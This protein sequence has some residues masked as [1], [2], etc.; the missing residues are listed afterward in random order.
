M[1]C[2]RC[3]GGLTVGDLIHVIRFWAKTSAGEPGEYLPVEAHLLDAGEVA[4]RLFDLSLTAQQQ[5]WIADGFGVSVERARSIAAFTA[6]SH[7]IGK[8]G[9]FQHLVP[10][11]ARALGSAELPGFL[12]APKRHDRVSGY[13]L[14]GY[15]VDH[16]ASRE[17]AE[18]L[19]AT[20]CG[21][22]S[23]PAAIPGAERRGQL[24]VLA[25]WRSYHESLLS[26]VADVFGPLSFEDVEVPGHGVTLALAGL[27]NV[28]DWN[29][30]DV[31]R[32]PV[33]TQERRGSA[34]LADDAIVRDAWRPRPVTADVSFSGAF[35]F[36][37]RAS[38]AAL[39]DLL[40]GTELP[41]LIL[42]EDRTG[43][44]KTEAAL[45]AS[46]HALATGARGLFVGLP[47]RAT[48]NQF[49]ARAARFLDSLWNEH[50]HDLRLLHGG[51]HPKDPADPEL[52]DTGRD[53]A[54]DD[55]V[56]ARMWFDG[57]RRGLLSPYAVGTVD[58]ALLAVLAA[59]F[60][61]VRLWGLAGKVVVIDEAHSY[62]TYTAGLLESLL[63]WLGAMDCTVVVLS[64][65][66]PRKIRQMLVAAYR[67]G[68]Q[69]P[70]ASPDGSHDAAGYPRL[71]LANRTV[72]CTLAVMDPRPGRSIRVKHASYVDD[73]AAV[74][75]AAIAAAQDGGCVAVVC[76]T[77]KL[78]QERFAAVRSAQ[79]E[80]PATLLHA[81]IRPLE[82]GPIEAA[83]ASQ[84]GP[85]AVGEA[86][87]RRLVVVATQV[88]EQSLD[89]DFDVMFTD[90]APVD[91]LVQR[92]GRVHRHERIGRPAA[93]REPVLTV[94]DA[95]GG[96]AVHRSLPIGA[97]AVYVNAVL[98]RTR[99]ALRG[100]SAIREPDDLDELIESVYGDDPPAGVGRE[101]RVAIV[102]QDRRAAEQAARHRAWAQ[103]N[104]I[105]PPHGEDPPWEQ[106]TSEI[107]D[108][109]SPG[110]G[111]TH[112]AVTRWSELPSIELVVLREDEAHLAARPA[113]ARDLLLRSV[114]ISDR[115]ITARVLADIDAH[116][117]AAWKR[118]GGL[119]H[120]ALTVTG[121][122][123][124]LDVR[125]DPELGV[126]V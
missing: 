106:A 78:A 91:L 15:L 111:P 5:R 68:L 76:S 31:G 69:V 7:D 9:P 33:T 32:F 18:A 28:S 112:A 73:S 49:H 99:A 36:E 85:E 57:A 70:G 96:E 87:P 100:R 79:P 60:Y 98:M 81:R 93:H 10:D 89:L 121:T 24:G 90:L 48:A 102:D 52:W 120:H 51:E 23:I 4:C 20:V 46:R 63:R 110:A 115:R 30:S 17:L 14:Y 126:I 84:L 47:T 43:S 22:H 114:G 113:N 103:E 41:A 122:E 62:D 61:P 101:E 123:A 125:W 67:E 38:Q 104:G 80:I 75:E 107:E 53:A 3:Q 64:A 77:V 27:V 105:G 12:D 97:G 40:Q 119:C 16:G 72:Q 83:L 34:L 71:T 55:L 44:G 35:G 11:L 1:I 2:S 95:P 45:W 29:A 65:T 74:A 108:G 39:V 94:L 86:R 19:T 92:A 116:R 56:T 50:H 66:L 25:P 6:A 37:P 109:D 118:H 59:R 26:L 124:E 117:P 88:I 54:S 8:V 42:I 21:H 82:R 13:I 58:Q